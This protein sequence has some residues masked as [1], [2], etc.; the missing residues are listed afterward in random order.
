MR[1]SEPSQLIT[2]SRRHKR[3]LYQIRMG[4][5]HLR[6]V[7]YP[8]KFTTPECKRRPELPQLAKSQE[9]PCVTQTN[10]SKDICVLNETG[11]FPRRPI[12][13]DFRAEYPIAPITVICLLDI[14]KIE[15]RCDSS[16][17]K[18]F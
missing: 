15:T 11:K 7:K 6:W 8:N 18:R 13:K 3:S 17:Q 4:D 16:G 10:K 2:S 12:S 1:I 5:K 14:K 9:I